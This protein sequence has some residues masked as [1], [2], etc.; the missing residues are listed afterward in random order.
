MNAR[1]FTDALAAD[2]LDLAVIGRLW[3]RDGGMGN[4]R[5]EED[6]SDEGCRV[7]ARHAFRDVNDLLAEVRE[8]RESRERAIRWAVHLENEN[9]HLT[10][11]IE[12]VQALETRLARR[13]DRTWVASIADDIEAALAG[14]E[15]E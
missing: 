12:A 3:S 10:A 4:E 11:R 9:A 5:S 8:L 14:G 1:S 6:Y 7:L 15:Q 13:N 2:P